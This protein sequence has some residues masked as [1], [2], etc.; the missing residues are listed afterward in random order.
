[1]RTF[2]LLFLLAWAGG[3]ILGVVGVDV[4]VVL[5]G[6][7]LF[8][9]LAV[10]SRQSFGMLAAGM[11]LI[12]LGYVW[13]ASPVG[14]SRVGGCEFASTA[15]VIVVGQPQLQA[16]S[17]RFVAEDSRSCRV[18][19]TASRFSGVRE[20][21][22]V[23]VSGGKVSDLDDVR[24]FSEGYAEYLKRR[25]ISATWGFAEVKVVHRGNE[26]F[27]GLHDVV[28]RRIDR[29]FIEP[30]A[31]V[32]KAMLLAERGTLPDEIVSNFRATGVSHV[33]AIS[34]LH[35]SLLIGMF[36]GLFM[37]MPLGPV[38]RTVVIVLMLWL[39]VVFIGAPISAVRAAS[40]WTIVLVAMRLQKLVSLPTV[41]L[42]TVTTLL[43]MTPRLIEEVGFQ[44]SVSAVT[45]IF[46]VL[47][48]TRNLL[49]RRQ[50]FSS[51]LFSS[52][53]VSL[54]ATL[55]TAPLVAYHFGNIALVGVLANVLVVPAVPVVLVL[56]MVS[57]AL[58]LLIEPA[59]Q[60]AAYLLHIVIA[61]VEMITRLLALAPGLFLEEVAVPIWLA[62]VYYLGL[63][64]VCIVLMRWQKRSWWEVWQ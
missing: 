33:L 58:S 47:F 2:F 13:G 42:L 28:R 39:Y 26:L 20:G 61:W 6:C 62:V 44:L 8:G 54:G 29:L 45:G 52:V 7:V 56:A 41:L 21:D 18:L 48:V 50:G 38:A 27:N 12:F 9:V 53:L 46:L 57:L 37:L 43:S 25:G 64:I 32:V 16:E 55:A 35:V 17:V 63:V 60:V 15:T 22:E 3:I 59:A 5:L 10:F 34:G 19:V 14:L 31:S 30:D 1:M 40:F 4:W 49:L 36:L 51:F 23:E 24:S 11:L